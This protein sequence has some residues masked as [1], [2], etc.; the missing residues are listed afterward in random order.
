MM[1]PVMRRALRLFLVTAL[2]YGSGAHWAAVQCAAWGGMLVARS[3]VS[4]FDEALTTTFDGAHPCGVCL[5][6][7]KGAAQK[8]PAAALPSVHFIAVAV[9]ALFVDDEPRPAR[10]P[11]AFQAP[12]PQSRPASP[13]P[14]AAL[15]A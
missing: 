11:A 1:G 9:P 3:T 8:P 2:L 7:E 6:V 14:K 5:V 10:A 13:P 15:L 4:G 12:A